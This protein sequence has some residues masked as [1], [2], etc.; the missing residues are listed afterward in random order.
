MMRRGPYHPRMPRFAPSRIEYR[1]HR[2]LLVLPSGPLPRPPA[3]PI[4]PLPPGWVLIT[5]PRGEDEWCRCVEC[6]RDVARG[7]A[8]VLA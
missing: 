5:R 2:C 4:Y 1:C 7:A 6:Q 3:L 8:E